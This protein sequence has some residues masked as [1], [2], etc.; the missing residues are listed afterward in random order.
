MLVR[1]VSSGDRI[2]ER[3]VVPGTEGAHNPYVGSTNTRRYAFVAW[4]DRHDGKS[5]VRLVRWDLHR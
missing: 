3:I 1:V 2:A 4:T 5:R